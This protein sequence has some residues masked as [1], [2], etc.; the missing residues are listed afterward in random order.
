MGI[1]WTEIT[2][3]VR[4]LVQDAQV[5]TT[6]RRLRAAYLAALRTADRDPNDLAP[7]VAFMLS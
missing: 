2:A 4:S 3:A 6:Q 5:W 7:L 1:G